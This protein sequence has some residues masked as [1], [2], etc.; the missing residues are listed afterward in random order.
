MAL[1]NTLVTQ[2]APSPSALRPRAGEP[3]SHVQYTVL[4]Y[5]YPLL[6]LASL[7]IEALR[8]R[9]HPTPSAPLYHKRTTTRSAPSRPKP[10][11]SHPDPPQNSSAAQSM[12]LQAP[13]PHNAAPTSRHAA[14]PFRPLRAR[15]IVA[16]DSAVIRHPGLNVCF[17]WPD[18]GTR[19]FFFWQS[20]RRDARARGCGCGC[21]FETRGEGWGARLSALGAGYLAGG[22]HVCAVLGILRAGEVR[23]YVGV[24]SW[25]CGIVRGMRYGRRRDSYRRER[26][27]RGRLCAP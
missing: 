19:G 4:N 14:C 27:E 26:V 9:Y 18:T 24:G 5:T 2:P 12:L 23:G 8:P 7:P 15:R 25:I 11:V 16:V 20:M 3:N 10:L 1:T 17:C 21:C 13:C 6:S 22:W